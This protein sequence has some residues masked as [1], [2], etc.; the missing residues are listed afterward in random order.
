MNPDDSLTARLAAEMAI[1]PLSTQDFEQICRL[2]YRSFGLD[3]KAG[4]EELVS[5]RL[6]RLVRDGG[7]RSF[8][9]YIRY[10]AAEPTGVALA[11]MIDALATNHTAFNREPA[12]FDF[13]RSDLVPQMARRDTVEV[14]SAACS[15]GEEAWTLAFLLNDLLAPRQVRI[16][17]SDI[18]TRALRFAER[19]VYPADRCQE[20]GPMW[21]NRYFEPFE[22]PQPAWRVAARVRSQATFRRLNLV[23]RYAWPRRFP[24]IFCRNVMI[25]FDSA[26]QAE[27]VRQ[28]TEWLEPGGY[29]LIG[30]A[31][32]LARISHTLE[33]VRPSIYRKPAEKEWKWRR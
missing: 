31:D 18:S 22:G 6:G 8:Q 20:V 26:T 33:Y 27:V 30:H 13:L 4:K 14:W 2:A 24:I 3:L 21:M 25:Y 9:E 12:H 1:R 28:L 10:I 5:A 11:S 7:F 15:T 19:A 16:A 29:L 32:S 23:E 17:A